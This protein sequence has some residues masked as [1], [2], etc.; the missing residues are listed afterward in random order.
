MNFNELPKEVQEFINA[1]VKLI[2]EVEVGFETD[3]I[4]DNDDLFKRMEICKSKY[5][6]LKRK[7]D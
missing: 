1:S 7:F 3:L 2:K 5:I 6:D 4:Q